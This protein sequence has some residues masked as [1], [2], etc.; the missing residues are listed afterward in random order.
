MNSALSRQLILS[1]SFPCTINFRYGATSTTVSL[2]IFGCD[3]RAA[4]S[5]SMCVSSIAAMHSRVPRILC[6]PFRGRTRMKFSVPGS[7]GQE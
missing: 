2:S 3:R 6:I 5:K 1:S 7:V 4:H